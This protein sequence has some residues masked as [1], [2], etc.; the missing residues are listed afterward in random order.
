MFVSPDDKESG[1]TLVEKLRELAKPHEATVAQIDL[2]LLLSKPVVSSIIIGATK[3]APTRRKP[4]AVDVKLTAP[5]SCRTGCDDGADADL[6]ELVQR[7]DHGYACT[8]QNV[9]SN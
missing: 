5:R 4:Q 7:N 9:T 1:F 2:A 6:S 8:H 3:T